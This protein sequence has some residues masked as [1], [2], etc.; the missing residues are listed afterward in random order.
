MITVTFIVISAQKTLVEEKIC[1]RLKKERKENI[2]WKNERTWW[3]KNKNLTE[4]VYGFRLANAGED[5]WAMTNKL[6]CE[7]HLLWIH[8]ILGMLAERHFQVSCQR[9][10]LFCCL[11]PQLLD[12]VSGE[13]PTPTV[14]HMLCMELT[15]QPWIT[16]K[17]TLLVT[18]FGLQVGTGLKPRPNQRHHHPPTAP[19]PP[20]VC[21]DNCNDVVSS[22]HWTWPWEVLRAR[23]QLG[24]KLVTEDKAVTWRRAELSREMRIN[25]APLLCLNS[26]I[27]LCLKP[28]FFTDCVLELINSISAC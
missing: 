14:G 4:T 25:W 13:I 10:L 23:L 18:G 20:G 26:C 28:S 22:S 15:L 5:F 24:R 7:T 27:Q 21:L 12:L 19:T 8:V 3:K 9:H 11:F 17:I 1:L 2:S 6:F 16:G